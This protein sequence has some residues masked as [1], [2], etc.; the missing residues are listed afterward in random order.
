ME[1]EFKTDEINFLDNT[2]GELMGS[3]KVAETPEAYWEHKNKPMYSIFYYDEYG[4]PPSISKKGF[5]TKEEAR[6]EMVKL[7]MELLKGGL[8]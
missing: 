8:K 6:E 2:T 3:Y 4:N 7:A 5:D 1:L